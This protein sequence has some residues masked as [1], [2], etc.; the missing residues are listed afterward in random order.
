MS[1]KGG[2]T[3]GFYDYRRSKLKL[4][5]VIK[6]NT[7]TINSKQEELA[8][9]RTS[10]QEVDQRITTIVS[11]QQK[12]DAKRGHHTSELE[13]LKHDIANATKQRMAISKAL[14][15]KKKLLA[16]A[17]NQIDQ[18][19]AGMAMKRAEM[20]TD[21]I[22]QLTPEEKALLSQLNPEITQFKEKLFLCKR[23]RI[24]TETRKSELETNL[25]TNLVR[26]QQELEAQLVSADSESLS[27]ELELKMQ[28]LG[29]AK[30][31]VD[32]ASQQLK[33]NYILFITFK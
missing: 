33:G 1:K 21:L 5:N 14:E 18:L 19:R 27:A 31:S 12:T 4:M 15:K 13:Q 25:S 30:A 23:K 8:K 9:V 26:R 7:K 3:G 6:Q 28:E 32:E 11:E 29:D 20:G 16:N 17:H 2:M 24:E 22:D 10:I